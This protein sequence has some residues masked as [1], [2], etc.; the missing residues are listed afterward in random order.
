[1]IMI[2]VVI[3]IVINSVDKVKFSNKVAKGQLMPLS[4]GG[5]GGL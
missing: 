1:M 5:N 3:V 4:G 2:V